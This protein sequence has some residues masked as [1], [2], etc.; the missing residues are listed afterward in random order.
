MGRLLRLNELLEKAKARSSKHSTHPLRTFFNRL[1]DDG[2]G[3]CGRV[4]YKGMDAGIGVESRDDF[5]SQSSTR[6]TL[7]AHPAV[8]VPSK[9]KSHWKSTPR[10]NIITSD[11][12]GQGSEDFKLLVGTHHLVEPPSAN[13]PLF[14]PNPE[15]GI[16][17]QY[18]KIKLTRHEKE[19][20]LIGEGRRV[21][22]EHCRFCLHWVSKENQN[23]CKN[24]GRDPQPVCSCGRPLL[25]G[26]NCVDCQKFSCE[27]WLQGD[28]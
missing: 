12:D 7:P 10:K 6:L 2:K 19:K 5:S 20:R 23:K 24:C 26:T 3:D 27:N 9:A 13:S 28:V 21:K 4:G 25:Y 11:E 8:R 16:T 22:L 18:Q 14:E 1:P 15:V 17:E